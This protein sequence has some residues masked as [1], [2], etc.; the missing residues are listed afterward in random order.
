MKILLAV[1]PGNDLPGVVNYLRRRFGGTTIDLDILTVLQPEGLGRWESTPL[2][3]NTKTEMDNHDRACSLV[4]DYAQKITRHCETG[5]VR[6]YVEYGDAAEVIL[7][8][9]RQQS[10]D[11]LVIGTP[12]RKGLLTAF[13]MDGITRRLLKWSDCPVE[14][15]KPRGDDGEVFRILVPLYIGAAENFTL[16]DLAGHCWPA[17]S[18]LHF[19][20]IM[21]SAIDTGSCEANGASVLLRLQEGRDAQGRARARLSCL[22]RAVTRQLPGDVRASHDIA[23][24]DPRDL[25]VRF[26]HKLRPD[27]VVLT[28]GWEGDTVPSPFSALAPVSLAL[29][30]PSS[31]LH[32]VE[33]KTVAQEVLP[34]GGSSGLAH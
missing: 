8:F 28:P 3:P 26:T 17:K 10:S 4:A 31:L 27:L 15:C 7:D 6:T 33:R 19:L 14:L 29:S 9:G 5:N 20:G 25:A 11:V 12:A 13:R 2:V 21:A 16:P 18:H 22:D 30:T 24:G 23:E 32:L 1:N 34:M